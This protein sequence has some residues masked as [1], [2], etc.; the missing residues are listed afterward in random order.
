MDE[1]QRCPIAIRCRQARSISKAIS[2]SIDEIKSLTFPEKNHAASDLVEIDESEFLRKDTTAANAFPT[3][4]CPSPELESSIPPRKREQTTPPPDLKNLDDSQEQG[5]KQRYAER[6]RN[7][8]RELASTLRTE[9]EPLK[10]RPKSPYHKYYRI[11]LPD[12]ED[13]DRL[14]SGHDTE[15]SDAHVNITDKY[16]DNASDPSGSSFDHLDQCDSNGG[17]STEREEHQRKAESGPETFES[18][19]EADD[20][21]AKIRADVLN[22]GPEP[23]PSDEVIAKMTIGQRRQVCCTHFRDFLEKQSSWLMVVGLEVC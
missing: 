2:K 15:G 21:A 22:D 9:Q 8:Q 18:A 14:I 10:P 17:H 7:M 13:G 12:V 6:K 16:L 1:D 5:G 4:N 11:D 20:I 3:V 19:S 23:R